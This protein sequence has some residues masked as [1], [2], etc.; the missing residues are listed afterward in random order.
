MLSQQE[1][2]RPGRVVCLGTPLNGS[3]VAQ[4]LRKT[5][6]GRR[7]LGQAGELLATGLQAFPEGAE[8]GMIAGTLG[9]GLGRL[10][11]PFDGPGDGTVA[12][13]ET[14]SDALADRLELAV[15]HTGLLFSAE[16]ARQAAFFIESGRFDHPKS[17]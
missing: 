14:R 8:C 16:V 6:A 17:P 10:T 15:G 4:R 2:I 7:V 13:D 5:G 9:R 3:L 11:G 1:V 12:L